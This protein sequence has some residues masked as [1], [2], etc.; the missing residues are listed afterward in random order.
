MCLGVAVLHR[1]TRIVIACPDPH[2][3]ATR[4]DPSDL[5]CFY[6]EHWPAI[7]VGLMKETAID[8]ILR[9]LRTEKFLSWETMLEEFSKMKK[10][11]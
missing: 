8:L 5:G 4:V 1:V 10:R 9:F 2:G 11:W 6:A 7:E 3:G